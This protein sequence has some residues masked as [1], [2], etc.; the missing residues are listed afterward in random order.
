VEG[1]RDTL[2]RLLARAGLLLPDEDRTRIAEYDDPTTLDRW[3]ENVL[4]ATKA[5]EVLTGAQATAP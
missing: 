5:S 3:C 1:K 2:L 4:G